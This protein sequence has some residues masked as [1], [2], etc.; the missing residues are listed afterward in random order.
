MSFLIIDSQYYSVIL[1]I[2]MFLANFLCIYFARK[3][4]ASHIC[5]NHLSKK[6]NEQW[7][8]TIHTINNGILIVSKTEVNMP[9]YLN[10]A[11]KN[12]IQEY[13]SNAEDNK[14]IKDILSKL[15]VKIVKIGS[16]E[17]AVKQSLMELTETKDNEKYY[18]D[19]TNELI[20]INLSTTIFEEEEA[21]L[22]TFIDCDAAKKI[23]KLKTENKHKTSLLSIVS[24]ELRNPV[25]IIMTSIELIS[26]SIPDCSKNADAIKTLD[27]SKECCQLIISQIN[28]LSVIVTSIVGLWQIIRL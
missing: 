19:N 21:N 25:S 23:E 12:M 16:F 20:E 6:I 18:L 4:T 11:L 28:D 22:I 7:K 27:I 26:K 2:N 13:F 9:L 1:I 5:G 24:H 8:S 14:E 10:P 17:Q 15:E 3:E